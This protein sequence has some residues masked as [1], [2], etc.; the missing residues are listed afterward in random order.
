MAFK[1]TA[2]TATTPANVARIEA[3]LLAIETLMGNLAARLAD[4]HE[5]EDIADYQARIQKEL[6]DG[7]IITKMTKRPFGFHFTIGTG[8]V[9]SAS[10]GATSYGW[11]RVG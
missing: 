7:F 3:M 1:V 5:Y 10:Y 6:P 2:A 11:K 8:A 9:Y 4:E